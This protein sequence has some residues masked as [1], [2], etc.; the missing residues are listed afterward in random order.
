MS[1]EI[2]KLA[3]PPKNPIVVEGFPS[4]GL[5]GSIATEFLATKL[6][7]KEIGFFKSSQLPPVAIIKDGI[8][9]APIRIFSKD[10][11]VVLVSDTA[12]P[13]TLTYEIAAAIVSWAK[14]NGAKKI[15]S[16][17]GIAREEALPNEVFMVSNQ[18][19]K[20]QKS[21]LKPIHLG[22]L[23]GVFSV[24][25]LECLRTKIPTYGF[26]APAEPDSPDPKAAAMVLDALATDLKIK[27]D[28]TSLAAASAKME[29]KMKELLDETKKAMKTTSYPSIYG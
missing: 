14:K 25:M 7:M 9:K 26:L 12:V 2:V 11:L 23:T 5:V 10:N 15:I 21:G 29:R 24:L 17:G 1:V 18:P 28:T 20:I 8:P 6:E 19:E 4:I 22:F 27:V 3:P 13:P 16:L